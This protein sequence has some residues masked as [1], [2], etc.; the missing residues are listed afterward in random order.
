LENS[1]VN[2]NR[3][4]QALFF[5]QTIRQIVHQDNKTVNVSNDL[6]YNEK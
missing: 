4:L 2:P 1:L 6:C 3:D 5:I